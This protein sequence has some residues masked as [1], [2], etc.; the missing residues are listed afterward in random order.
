MLT[1]TVIEYLV[2]QFAS[3]AITQLSLKH[4]ILVTAVLPVNTAFFADWS[5]NSSNTA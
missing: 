3:P 1:C 2:T 4:W 5:R